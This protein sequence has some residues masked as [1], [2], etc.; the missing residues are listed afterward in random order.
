MA[1]S[2]L[3]KIARYVFAKLVG[4]ILLEHAR[5]KGNRNDL[6]H[7]ANQKNPNNP[8]YTAT[9]NNRAN[10]L[11]PNNPAYSKSRANYQR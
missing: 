6:N 4:Y 10:Q 11:D 9:R 7:H 5:S 8:A 3:V 2:I 1:K